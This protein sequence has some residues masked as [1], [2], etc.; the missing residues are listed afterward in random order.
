[1]ALKFEI[2]NLG[3]KNQLSLKNLI[4]GETLLLAHGNLS[5]A[6]TFAYP[7][8]K[9][10]AE[11]SIIHHKWKNQQYV[12]EFLDSCKKELEIKNPQDWYQVSREQIHNLGG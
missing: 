3:G 6:L 2:K 12:R 5:N 1:M 11:R 10:E 4:L 9:W 8:E 7:E